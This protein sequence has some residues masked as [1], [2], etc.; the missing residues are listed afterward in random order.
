M[1]PGIGKIVSTE[2]T[3]VWT[4]ANVD[5][6]EI[7]EVL[8]CVAR[9]AGI[10]KPPLVGNEVHV[11]SDKNDVFASALHTCDPGRLIAPS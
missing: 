11:P 7:E 4:T 9:K 1:R 3:S 8:D 2:S 10:A 5:P 6:Q